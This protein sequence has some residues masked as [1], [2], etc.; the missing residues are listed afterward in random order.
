MNESTN[1]VIKSGA[2]ANVNKGSKD[3]VEDLWKYK[4]LQ[5][6]SFFGLSCFGT[7]KSY[8]ILKSKNF[9]NVQFISNR[10]V[11][12][13]QVGSKV[14]L[15]KGEFGDVIRG[16]CWHRMGR[17]AEFKR[18]WQRVHNVRRLLEKFNKF[19]RGLVWLNDNGRIV[20]EVRCCWFGLETT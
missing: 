5:F 6:K 20:W 14:K 8:G 2:T 9:T 17:L 13:G 7:H 19:M 15:S 4:L 16:K 12:G 18:E 3:Q 1:E 10:E 11:K